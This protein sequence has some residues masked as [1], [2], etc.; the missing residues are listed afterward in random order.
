MFAFEDFNP[1][2]VCGDQ[3]ML[4]CDGLCSS[5]VRLAKASVT[6]G[7]TPNELPVIK[8]FKMLARAHEHASMLIQRFAACVAYAVVEQTGEQTGGFRQVKLTFSF[9]VPVVRD[10]NEELEAGK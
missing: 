3:E 8:E 5:C 4:D 10:G 7:A 1:C 2:R 9:L 6:S